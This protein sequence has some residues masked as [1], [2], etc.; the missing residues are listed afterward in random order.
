MFQFDSPG[1]I[2]FKS[3]FTKFELETSGGIKLVILIE[4]SDT[5][6]P[7]IMTVRL[8][9]LVCNSDVVNLVWEN[10]KGEAG[11]IIVNFC[12]LEEL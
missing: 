2:A 11:S 1:G 6:G 9:Y 3:R 8:E 7:S 4:D 10:N 5:G 12:H